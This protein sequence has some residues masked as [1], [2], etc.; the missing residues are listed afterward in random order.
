MKFPVLLLIATIAL[1][2]ASFVAS[3]FAVLPRVY[4]ELKGKDMIYTIRLGLFIFAID[5]TFSIMLSFLEDII[6]LRSINIAPLIII[7]SFIRALAFLIG[8]VVLY[9]LYHTHIDEKK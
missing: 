2:M 9:I 8:I 4:K 5:Y 6:Y 3:L 1:K 7:I